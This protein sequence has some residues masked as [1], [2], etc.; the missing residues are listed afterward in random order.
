MYEDERTCNCTSHPYHLYLFIRIRSSEAGVGPALGCQVALIEVAPCVLFN[1][2]KPHLGERVFRHR[3]VQHQRMSLQSQSNCQGSS[4]DFEADDG[5][6]CVWL[7]FDSVS[8]RMTV[9]L[10]A[11]ESHYVQRLQC[12]Y[13]WVVTAIPP[14]LSMLPRGGRLLLGSLTP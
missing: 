3:D 6:L 14:S 1:A 7:A 13:T 8:P 12:R 10:A 4:P 2:V 9:A 11:L 5:Q